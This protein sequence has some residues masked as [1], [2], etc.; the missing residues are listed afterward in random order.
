VS[1]KE[2]LAQHAQLAARRQEKRQRLSDAVKRGW[3]RK[4]LAHCE[5]RWA[6]VK[7]TGSP[8]RWVK[9]A[10]QGLEYCELRWRKV[11]EQHA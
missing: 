3:E 9:L 6:A 7:E 8:E 10:V 5:A 1:F 4:N 2:R 11:Q